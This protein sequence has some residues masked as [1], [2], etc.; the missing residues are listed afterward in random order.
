[1]GIS[2]APVQVKL[3]AG[4]PPQRHTGTEKTSKRR[5]FSLCLCVFA[6]IRPVYPGCFKRSPPPTLGWKAPRGSELS[7]TKDEQNREIPCLSSSVI[8]ENTRFMN[9]K[10][11][12]P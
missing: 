6:V 11:L 9:T 1:M 8:A 5:F 3:L 10:G 12:A 7:V 2:H 4:L